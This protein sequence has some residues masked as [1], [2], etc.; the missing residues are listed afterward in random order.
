MGPAHLSLLA[1]TARLARNRMSRP[2]V[3]TEALAARAVVVRPVRRVRRVRKAVRAVLPVNQKTVPFPGLIMAAT[4]A[5][6]PGARVAQEV[7]LDAAEVPALQVVVGPGQV[8]AALK[9]IPRITC[10]Y[11]TAMVNGCGKTRGS[12]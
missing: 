4:L 2:E 12:P 5:V 3:R 6:V 7:A 9:V 11:W 8:L 1:C 10:Q